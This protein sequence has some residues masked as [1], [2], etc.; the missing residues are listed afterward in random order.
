M[1][2]NYV[3]VVGLGMMGV[4]I[5][6]AHLRVGVPVLLYDISSSILDSVLERIEVELNSQGLTLDASLVVCTNQLA[7]IA[8]LPVIIETVTEKL[9]VKQ[10]LYSELQKE[11][12]ELGVE[13]LIFS[14]TSTISITKLAEI[15]D[16]G[17]RSRFCGLHFFHPVR[18][19]SLVEIIAGKDTVKSTIEAAKQHAYR[20]E[21]QP[22]EVKDCPGFLVN[23]ILHGYLSA[24]LELFESGV[25]IS[26]IEQ[27]AVKFGMKMGPFRIM[28]EIGL[29]VVLQAG[30]VLQK[31][32]PNRVS[33]SPTLLKLVEA[34]SL[35]RKTGRG[36]M[37]YKSKN[38]W[39][40]MDNEIGNEGN[41]RINP[42]IENYQS[43]ININ[44]EIS[45][46]QIIKRLLEKMRAEA[47]DCYEDGVIDNIAIADIASIQALGFPESIGGITQYKFD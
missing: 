8:K 45:D 36:F 47:I 29:D 22:I 17:W 34:R 16:V 11:S 10:R 32:F 5:A 7:D 9:R 26:R 38:A 28:D 19:R 1:R 43:L 46:N 42:D 20:I 25:A 2:G 21:K 40:E 31:A 27:A 44:N 39:N 13:S 30:W 6:A 4:A 41:D 23:R 35:G 33:N 24:A 37:T 3:G 15:F 18:Q 14:N 12:A